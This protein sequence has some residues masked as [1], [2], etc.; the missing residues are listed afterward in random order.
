MLVYYH[1][2]IRIS[3]WQ[4]GRFMFDGII[5]FFEYFIK[6]FL[7]INLSYILDVNYKVYFSKV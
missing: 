7:R 5:T 2:H 3:L 6:M 4:F 1:M